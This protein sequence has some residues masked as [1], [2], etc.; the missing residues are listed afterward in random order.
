MI[1]NDRKPVVIMAVFAAAGLLLGFLAEP[2]GVP[3]VNLCQFKLATGLPCPGCGLTRATI[4]MA[5]GDFTRAWMYN[6]FI[7]AIFPAMVVLAIYPF[8]MA[9]LPER[10]ISGL[11][12]LFVRGSILL[13]GLMV[14]Y[15]CYRWYVI[16]TAGGFGYL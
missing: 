16:F 3:S 11:D 15:N 5:H 2:S 8:I 12:W 13:F 7:L 6:P 9:Q 4:L 10:V 1:L 14:I